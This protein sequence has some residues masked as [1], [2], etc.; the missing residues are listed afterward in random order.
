[1]CPGPRDHPGLGEQ[2][3]M[4]QR[5]PASRPVS[6]SPPDGQK[7][8]LAPFQQ[9]DDIQQG[10]QLAERQH[11]EQSGNQ[12]HARF[13]QSPQQGRVSQPGT[14]GEDWRPAPSRDL[15]VHSILN[16]A[17]PE[18]AHAAQTSSRRVSTGTTD[19]Q[20]STT[21]P[22][23]HFAPSPMTGLQHTVSG[24][25]ASLNTSPTQ[26]GY[27]STFSRSR[28]SSPRRILTPKGARTTILHR[29][30][31]GTIDAQRSPFI[32]H[33]S[34][35]GFAATS[36]HAGPPDAPPAPTPTPPERAHLQHY[37]FPPAGPSGSAP[38]ER[39]PSGS[40]RQP[41]ERGSPAQS[42]SPSISTSAGV[43][44]SQ[45]SPASFIY[46]GGPPPTSGSYFPGSS[47]A[48]SMQQAQGAGGPQFQTS[49]ASGT[50]GASAR[51]R[52]R[53]K[54]KEKE[55][56]TTIE[57]MQQQNR[58]LERRIREAESERDF[59]RGERDRFRDV[60][61]RSKDLRHLAMQAPPSP[62]SM[63]STS[64]QG[65]AAPG[66]PPP[67]PLGYQQDPST[68]ERAPRRRRTDTS[69]DFTNVP[70]TLPPASTLPPVLS[71]GYPPGQGP[72][73]LPPL[74]MNDP[75]VPQGGPPS[76]T[77]STGPPPPFESFP[78]PQYDRWG[79]TDAARR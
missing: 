37:G 74:R 42:I 36:G 15:A 45:A 48:P 3:S 16:P 34:G 51:F 11:P 68:S 6:R 28:G 43:S 20:H 21:G 30:S 75:S 59:Y 40:S 56:S 31:Q 52:Q 25:P 38:L 54:E 19:S 2:D 44:S 5:P 23:A 35:V 4:S 69:G 8:T 13:Q 39:H 24:Q 9:R 62:Q 14:P 7:I 17:E 18:G 49:S 76:L 53:R 50:E 61:Y 73:S 63:R 67:P 46:K 27:K 1:Q 79:P 22:P 55:A 12:G 29:P 26:E 65:Q 78:R 64:F 77:P 41:A 33:R 72:P 47:F 71:A 66:G 70:Y 10:N 32:P 58:E 60:L 57:K